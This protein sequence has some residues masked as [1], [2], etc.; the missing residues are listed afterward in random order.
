MDIHDQIKELLQDIERREVR[1]KK[2]RH[3]RLVKEAAILEELSK[4]YADCLR[5]QKWDMANEFLGQIS[6]LVVIM[7]TE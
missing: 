3:V 1:D 6:D 4:G 2:N 5:E 7:R